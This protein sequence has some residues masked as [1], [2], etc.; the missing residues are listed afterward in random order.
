MSDNRKKIVILGATGSIGDNTLKVVRQH[1]DKL[2]IVGVAC[3]RSHKKLAT[4]CEEFQVPH[5][6]IYNEEA[7]LEGK[8]SSQFS[9]TQLHEGLDGLRELSCISEADTVLVAVVGTMGLLP[10]LEAV[11][12][13]KDL[14]LASKEIL[15]MAG[16][17]FT[18]E[19]KK[20]N[21]RLLPVDSEHNAIFQCLHAIGKSVESPKMESAKTLPKREPTPF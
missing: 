5:A 1:R 15:V 9:N 13:G 21:V 6:A 14:A 20:A 16:R 18:E 3:N 4:I 7:Y 19:V 12:S 17:F 2:R 8:R 10:A 11:R